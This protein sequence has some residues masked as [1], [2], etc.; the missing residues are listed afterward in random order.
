MVIEL[1]LSLFFSSCSFFEGFTG[2][3]TNPF[4]GEC[5]VVGTIYGNVY[6]GFKYP[7]CKLDTARRTAAIQDYQNTSVYGS[8]SINTYSVCLLLGIFATLRLFS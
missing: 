2:C 5:K 1:K 8:S 7:Y 6:A 3:F 4:Q